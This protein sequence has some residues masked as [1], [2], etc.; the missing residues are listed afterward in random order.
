MKTNN[1]KD[2]RKLNPICSAAPGKSEVMVFGK[3]YHHNVATEDDELI[4]II[5]AK[6]QVE[7]AIL[8]QSVRKR[9][10]TIYGKPLSFRDTISDLNFKL[11]KMV[12]KTG[13]T[14]EEIVREIRNYL[15][16]KCSFTRYDESGRLIPITSERILE[17]HKLI[18]EKKNLVTIENTL[19][20]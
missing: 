3:T 8:S 4:D 9:I 1:L 19:Y 2:L 15:G 7:Y 6:V 16:Y 20:L 13:K 10:I 12:E 17:A 14:I 5:R 18:S 11:K